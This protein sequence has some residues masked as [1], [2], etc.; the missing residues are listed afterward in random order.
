MLRLRMHKFSDFCGWRI[1]VVKR[2]AVCIHVYPESNKC[3]SI[4]DVTSFLWT[5]ICIQYRYTMIYMYIYIYNIVKNIIHFHYTF[6]RRYL[7]HSSFRYCWR[8]HSWFCFVSTCSNKILQ[9]LESHLERQDYLRYRK[10]NSPIHF[11]SNTYKVQHFHPMEAAWLVA[12]SNDQW[13]KA[14]LVACLRWIKYS[15]CTLM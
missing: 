14:S 11:S 7:Y 10:R 1:K 9:T 2:G 3:Q 5:P 12:I 4:C 8:D 15:V 13:L 6:Y